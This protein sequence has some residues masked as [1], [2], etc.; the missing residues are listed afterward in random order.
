VKVVLL[1]AGRGTRL[2]PLT[3]TVPKILAP[4][5]GKPLLARQLRYLEAQGVSE[6]LLN[7]HHHAGA[8][9]AFLALEQ[10]AVK[11]TLYR[12]RQL[13]GT[14]G[15]LYPMAPR[16]DAEPFLVLYGDVVTDTDLASLYR[17]ARGVA[18]LGY[19]VAPSVRGKGVI[20]LDGDG[21]VARFVEKPPDEAEG[22]VNAGIYVLDPAIFEFIPTRGDF[23][24]DVWPRVLANDMPIY[25][26]I[27][28]GY[29]LDMG[30]PDALAQLSRDIE[31]GV[32]VW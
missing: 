31:E 7:L 15:A 14:A 32:V 17:T 11:L 5:A 9:E 24:F 20:E 19:H 1:A 12:E 18:T 30:D 3:V 22:L 16:L 29:L 23:G 21:R 4:V 13:R 2:A 26:T 10:P 25:G 8:V 6:V 27:I 28:N